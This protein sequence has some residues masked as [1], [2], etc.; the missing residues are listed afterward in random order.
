[1]QHFHCVLPRVDPETFTLKAVH[2]YRTAHGHV[3]HPWHNNQQWSMK[4]V[5][6]LASLPRAVYVTGFTIPCRGNGASSQNTQTSSETVHFLMSV[7]IEGT[8]RGMRYC[9]CS[10]TAAYSSSHT[11]HIM[12][13]VW[14]TKNSRTFPRLPESVCPSLPRR[15]HDMLCSSSHFHI[16]WITLPSSRCRISYFQLIVFSRVPSQRAVLLF[17]P[18]CNVRCHTVLPTY[19]PSHYAISADLLPHLFHKMFS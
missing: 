16:S 11:R 13:P 3:T 10:P 17:F 7:W 1:M 4:H 19:W 5:P 18:G 8:R 9:N 12:F 14:E 6:M 15:S 2:H